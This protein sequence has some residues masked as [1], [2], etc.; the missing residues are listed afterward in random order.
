MPITLIYLF[1]GTYL[2]E[3]KYAY[4]YFTDKQYLGVFRVLDILAITY[5]MVTFLEKKALSNIHA[6]SPVIALGRNSLPAFSLSLILCYL[7]S[8]IGEL[9]V[10]SRASYLTL[11]LTELLILYFVGWTLSRNP[12]IENLIS[13]KSIG[14][15][16]IFDR[17]KRNN[18]LTE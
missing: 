3:M 5:L 4:F 8:L 15:S 9:V 6:L 14:I 17:N 2:L 1:L 7:F 16:A 13:L 10:H 12:N 18:T 11:L